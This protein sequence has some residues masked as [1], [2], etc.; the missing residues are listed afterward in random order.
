MLFQ[1]QEVQPL[2]GDWTADGQSARHVMKHIEDGDLILRW[3]DPWR[4]CR[5]VS[6]AP[7]FKV[8]LAIYDRSDLR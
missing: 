2:E 6:S 3:F 1:V 7:I 5:V 8:F 4:I